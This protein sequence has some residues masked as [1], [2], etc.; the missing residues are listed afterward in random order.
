MKNNMKAMK[1]LL[2]TT[3]VAFFSFCL[4]V[5]ALASSI[6]I[7]GQVKDA[8]SQ[9]GVSGVVVSDGQQCVQTNHK[10][11]YK[12]ISNSKKVFHVFIVTPSAYEVPVNEN[13]IFNG[14]I[15]IDTSKKKN[16]CDF[17]LKKR[18][19]ECNRYIMCYMGDPQA[20]SQR[21]HSVES[22]KYLCEKLRKFNDACTLPVYQTF[23]GDM[24]TNEIE[25]KGKAE[26]FLNIM[27]GCG[28]KSF[29]IPGN[30]DHIQNSKIYH[31]AIAPYAKHFGPYNYAVNIGQ[32]H[33]IFLDNCAWGESLSGKRFARGLN[34]EACTFLKEDLK[35]VPKDT[36]LMISMHCPMTRSYN[37]TFYKIEVGEEELFQ[38]LQ[39][40]DVHFWY[41]HTHSYTNYPYSRVSIDKRAKGLR[42]L[43]SHTVGRCNGGWCCSSEITQD[44]VPRGLVQ[45][46]VDGKQIS[47]HFLSFDENY[48]D[49]MNVYPPASFLDKNGN[50]DM[51]LYCNVY[52]WD[53]KCDKPEFWSDGKLV[54]KM[55]RILSGKNA[56]VE[57]L[58][59]KLY[60]LW[61]SQGI[62]GFRKEVPKDTQCTHLFGIVPGK[63]ITSGEVRYTDRF[64]RKCIRK[65]S[66]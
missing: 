10:G 33:Y 47:W 55:E 37:G 66:W 58:Y 16:R 30:H 27:A 65:V 4:S 2:L 11:E 42:S 29:Y 57:P 18:D 1:K 54:G 22:C 32:V 46:D 51:H 60:P 21:P 56:T 9:K 23:L 39:D 34:K 19:G 48:P 24:V 44:G 5:S 63:E 25:V 41:G 40:R 13:G 12:I 45:V 20:M 53:S 7:F 64:G 38:A 3:L 36:P 43:E 62:E 17:T 52:L 14:Y 35:F 61:E 15:H 26:R 6:T 49:D 31:E 50:R 8:S 59:A 28:G